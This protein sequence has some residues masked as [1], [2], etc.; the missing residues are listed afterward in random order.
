M[1]PPISIQLSDQDAERVRRSHEEGIRELQSA[2]FASA[3]VVASV[4]LASG[5]ATTVPHRLGR[6]PTFVRESCPR[7]ASSTGR[8]EEV[9]DGTV[10]R[11]K[12][13]VLKA[14]GWGAT[15]TVDVLVL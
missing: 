14:T 15:I 7:G 9:R 12:A 13:V 4:S 3:M 6:A 10:D 8:V 2:P 1:R 5:I 11:T